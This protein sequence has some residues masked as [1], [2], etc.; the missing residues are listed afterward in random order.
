MRARAASCNARSSVPLSTDEILAGLG[1]V[2]ALGL[3]CELLAVRTRVPAILLLLPA[4]FIAGA[5]T[6]DV[7]PAALFG[8]TFQPLVSIGV[9]LIL[10]E[11]GLRLKLDE[12]HGAARDVVVRLIPLGTLVTATGVTIA[13]K[14]IFGLSWGAAVVLGAVLVVSGPT[15]VLPLLAFVR[16]SDRVRTVLKWEGV[17]IDPIGAL[18]G[19]LAFHAVKAGAG[20]QKPFHFGELLGSV[21]VGVLVGTVGAGFLW[22]LIKGIQRAAP[23]QGIAAAIMVVVAAVVAAD[24]IREDSGFVAATV[25]GVVLANQHELDISKVLEFQATVVKL[26]I[27]LLFVLISASVKP[28]TV[29]DLLPQGITLLAVMILLIRP[30][31]VVL[32]TRGSGLDPAERKFMACLAP[33][34]IVAAATASAFGPQLAAAGVGGAAKILPIAFIAIF[35]TV[36]FYGLTA[37]PLARRLGLAGSGGDLVLVIGGQPWARAI[38][39]ALDAAGVSVRVWT[40]DPA[41]QAAVRSAGLEVGNASL[42]GDAAAREDALEEVTDALLL[43]D[44]DNFNALAAYELRRDLG[45]DHVFR[46]T[47]ASALLDIEPAYAEGRTLFSPDLTFDEF[48]RRVQAGAKVVAVPGPLNGGA[49]ITPLFVVSRA[50]GVG[51]VTAGRRPRA[52]AG[53]TTIGLAETGAGASA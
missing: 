10:F 38:A 23:A 19:V 52:S 9:G 4:G 31:A 34:G 37:A 51:V 40:G 11:A 29:V 41:E 36:V 42:G 44:S 5:A 43:T 28:S 22:L 13:A 6:D 39:G 12:L 17:L 45:N 27:G 7:H 33:R 26:I 24:L 46:L 30:L 47:A 32:G 48:S 14:L 25:M 8:A 3:G 1:L 16:P 15:V 53:D 18:L 21:G 20:G 49:G 50:G 35:G 2:I